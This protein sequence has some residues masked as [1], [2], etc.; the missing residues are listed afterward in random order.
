MPRLGH[1]AW[2]T[3]IDADKCQKLRIWRNDCAYVAHKADAS[4]AYAESAHPDQR[5]LKADYK[6]DKAYDIFLS[7]LRALHQNKSP[8]EVR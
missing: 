4:T 7:I 6:H 3:F 5:I 1:I 8:G 2:S